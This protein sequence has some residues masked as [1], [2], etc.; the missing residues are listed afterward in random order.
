[1]QVL[2][3]DMMCIF[4]LNLDTPKRVS[5]YTIRSEKAEEINLSGPKSI[6]DDVI[7]SGKLVRHSDVKSSIFHT[8]IDGC[9]GII[10]RNILSV[11]LIDEKTNQAIGAIHF[12]NKFE[13]TASFSILDE[14][15]AVLYA[16]MAVTAILSCQK[17]HHVSFRADVLTSILASSS[18]LL[19]LIP[20][21]DSLYVKDI[22]HYELL[23]MLEDCTSRALKCLKVK[24]FLVSNRLDS[25]NNGFLLS[26][27]ER[28][29]HDPQ[30]RRGVFPSLLSTSIL[31]GVAGF[32]AKH[33]KWTIQVDGK[34]DIRAHPE[35]D[36][37]PHEMPCVTA[38]ILDLKGGVIG[39]LQM[40]CGS[41]SPKINL[42][43]SRADGITFEQSVQCLLQTLSPPLQCILAKIGAYD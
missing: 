36:L 33:K 26:I 3:V 28:N 20:D 43:D 14:T 22:S 39:C 13:G 29:T 42:T 2:D 8:E 6:V 30:H 35:V 16:E 40:I 15:F 11:P 5:K 27:Q 23:Q 18:R 31:S 9:P 1:M 10:I 21:S 7:Q 37:D 19:S 4:I 38:P 41:S 34:A 12:H 25:M 32:V 24:A 17:Y